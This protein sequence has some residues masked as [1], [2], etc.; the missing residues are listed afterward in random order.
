VNAQFTPCCDV[1]A[2]GITLWELATRLLPYE[3][4]SV[5]SIRDGVK[6]GQRP[7]IPSNVPTSFADLIR[8]CWD[9]KPEK[10]PTFGVVVEKL[11]VIS[12]AK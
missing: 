4:Q 6:E 1:Y 2:Y 12:E 10:R 7:D 9:Q 3:N 11:K 8:E 5:S